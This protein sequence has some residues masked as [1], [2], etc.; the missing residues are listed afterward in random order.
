MAQILTNSHQNI[1]AFFDRRHKNLKICQQTQT[2]REDGEGSFAVFEIE[3]SDT[4]CW[5]KCRD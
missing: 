2:T 3:Q 1:W 4:V 5:G